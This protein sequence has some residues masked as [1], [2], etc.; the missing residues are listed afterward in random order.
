MQRD[1]ITLCTA[2]MVEKKRLGM[3]IGMIRRIRVDMRSQGNDLP[4]SV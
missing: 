4:H 2:I 1:D 3:K